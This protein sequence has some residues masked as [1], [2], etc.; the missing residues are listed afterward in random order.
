MIAASVRLHYQSRAKKDNKSSSKTDKLRRRSQQI[1]SEKSTDVSSPSKSG[2]FLK[3]EQQSLRKRSGSVPA[4]KCT[5]ATIWGIKTSHVKALKVTWVRLCDTPRSNCKGI[6]AIVE[7]VFDKLEL[8]DKSV[9]EVFYNT[10]FVDS[11]YEYA[12]RRRPSCPSINER[13]PKCAAHTHCGLREH[14]HFF[15]SLVSQIIKALDD[16]PQHI[17]EHINRVAIF[18]A[19]L[20]QYGFRASSFDRL[21]E[22]L[23]D[24]LVVQETVRCFPEAC[25]AWTILIAAITDK[26]RS[27]SSSIHGTSSI[28]LFDSTTSLD[29]VNTLSSEYKALTLKNSYLGGRQLPGRSSSPNP[30]STSSGKGK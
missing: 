2:N 10:A 15:V 4:L 8:K 22:L 13:R 29:K 20:K 27:P 12:G 16:E 23:V 24:S 5:L 6:V 17:I 28:C 14:I 26:L 21:G 18:H 9:K 30:L 3:V 25:K 11:V 19:N 7:K 1:S